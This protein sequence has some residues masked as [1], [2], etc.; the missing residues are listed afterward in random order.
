MWFLFFQIWVWLLIAF[1]L[2]WFAHWFFCC[3][4]KEK[5]E[6]QTTEPQAATYFA[7]PAEADINESV[8]NIS[9]A[10]SADWKPMLFTSAPAQTDDLKQIKGIGSV[11]QDKLNELG[12]YQFQQIADWTDE[13]VA[14]MNDFL[15]F[16][17]RIDREEWREQA[18]VLAS[19][20]ET[21]FSQ[22]V[23]KGDLE[24]D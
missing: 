7:N 5:K 13:H 8:S 18:K 6:D 14:W 21:E 22:R 3:R 17:G 16:S 1:A 2:G 19:G 11:L 10:V 15:S 20:G 9:E 23:E 4:G 24:Y 12:V